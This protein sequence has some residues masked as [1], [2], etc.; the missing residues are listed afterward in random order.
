MPAKKAAVLAFPTRPRNHSQ[1]TNVVA[2]AIAD[3]Q[4]PRSSLSRVIE[5][6]TKSGFVTFDERLT[7]ADYAAVI[8]TLEKAGYRIVRRA[9][10]D[11]SDHK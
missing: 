10:V 9:D 11:F 8:T 1:L 6:L 7:E 5:V 3:L 2:A 4:I